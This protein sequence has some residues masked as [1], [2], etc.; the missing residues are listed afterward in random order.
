MIQFRAGRKFYSIPGIGLTAYGPA[1]GI[2]WPL[3]DTFN[4]AD[5]A[6]GTLP[7]SAYAW[8]AP[9]YTISSNVAT[10]TPSLSGVE[11]VT[12]GA[13]TNWTGDDPDNWTVT[14][15]DANN[16]ITEVAA[17][18]ASSATTQQQ[19]T[20]RNRLQQRQYCGCGTRSTL[21]RYPWCRHVNI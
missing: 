20:P 17:S 19:L 6:L 3:I 7:G 9:N 8:T 13:F 10:C 18:S 2:T 21:R 15:E 14:N 12:N 16:Y 5:G 11:L 4:R 1:S